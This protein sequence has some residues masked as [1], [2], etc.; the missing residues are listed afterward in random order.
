VKPRSD[1]VRAAIK[2]GPGAK[3]AL[4]PN[5]DVP[6]KPYV[7]NDLPALDLTVLVD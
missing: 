2:I 4:D 7:D 5:R 3:S 1:Y 6:I